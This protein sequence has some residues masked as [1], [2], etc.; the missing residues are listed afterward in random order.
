MIIIV[1]DER[2]LD[3]IDGRQ[4]DEAVGDVMGIAGE[5]A[6]RHDLRPAFRGGEA[7]CSLDDHQEGL[8]P[9]ADSGKRDSRMGQFS[10][11]VPP[12]C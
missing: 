1:L 11:S 4:M 3:L 2:A 7:I 9:Q 6:I 8:A 12:P 10:Y 5:T